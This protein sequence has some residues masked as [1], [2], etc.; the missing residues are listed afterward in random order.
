MLSMLWMFARI[1]ECGS[2]IRAVSPSNGFI[3][4]IFLFWTCAGPAASAGN[5]SPVYYGAGTE[6]LR[7]GAMR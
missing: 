1:P 6:F 7:I 5:I 3:A 2:R 4:G